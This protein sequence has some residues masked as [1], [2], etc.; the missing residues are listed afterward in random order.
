MDMEISD[1]ELQKKPR[2][3]L[4]YI[5][6]VIDNKLS[7]ILKKFDEHANRMESIFE[8][9]F[10][11]QR[12]SN[13]QFLTALDIEVKAMKEDLVSMRVKA[14]NLQMQ[15]S[16]ANDKIKA[17]EASSSLSLNH[18]NGIE[19]H[20]MKNDVFID[21]LPK[22]NTDDVDTVMEAFGTFVRC[23]LSARHC[24]YAFPVQAKD[25]NASAIK[26]R[27]KSFDKKVELLKKFKKLQFDDN[28][29]FIPIVVADFL[30]LDDENR[31]K[32]SVVNINVATTKSTRVIFNASKKL[33]KQ[34]FKNVWIDY[35]GFVKASLFSGKIIRITSTEDLQKYVNKQ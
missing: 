27:F 33:K 24:E 34:L 29:K 10:N 14:D 16:I 6:D 23:D 8:E 28:K 32:T 11:A 13:N 7:A 12:E 18:I 35:N 22:M 17:L 5:D 1:K 30:K 9:K 31:A 21:G 20:N 4:S 26:I 25:K 15:L 2:S 3:D 19:Q